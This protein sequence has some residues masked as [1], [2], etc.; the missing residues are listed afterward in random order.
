MQSM[1]A[2]W[3]AS[4]GIIKV[5]QFNDHLQPLMMKKDEDEEEEPCGLNMRNV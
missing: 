5:A 3:Q 1:G 2:T 4:R